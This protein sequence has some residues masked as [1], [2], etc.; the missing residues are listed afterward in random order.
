MLITDFL[1]EEQDIGFKSYSKYVLYSRA[2]PSMID[3]FKPGQRKIIY[4]AGIDSKFHK[5]AAFAGKV[6]SLANYHHG[7]SSLESTINGMAAKWNNNI[8]FIEGDGAFG[9]RLVTEAAS[10]RYTSCSLSKNFKIYFKDLDHEILPKCDDLL[11]PEPAYYVP[12]LPTVLL[13]G[14]KGIS[15][16]FATNIFPYALKDLKSTVRKIINNKPLPKNLIPSFPDFKGT[17]KREDKQVICNGLYSRKGNTIDV[18]EIPPEI[19]REKYLNHLESLYQKNIITSYEDL[20]DKSGF[21]F[22]I[23]M[24]ET[25]NILKTL[26]LTKKYNENITVISPEHKV[27]IYDN[28]ID[29]IKD[30]VAFRLNFYDKR[31]S[32]LINKYNNNIID[33]KNRIRFINNVLDNVIIFK[34][35]NKAV[36]V[37]ELDHKKYI[38]IDKLLS[39]PMISLT[40]D[41]IKDLE[42]QLLTYK[43]MIDKLQSTSL[44]QMYLDE[45]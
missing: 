36:M 28:P 42:D 11:D 10:P 32:F 2:I 25:D 19:S 44:E 20:C 34:N 22:K 17:I 15:V 41:K 18:T 16:G 29:L 40:E 31:K 5:T 9:S 1:L 27:L 4:T 39:L 24:R 30:F 21:H 33:L 8:T 12:V 7:P 23:R 43:E 26:K 37:E 13:N 38:N 35:K 14:I 6:I 3:G 45:I